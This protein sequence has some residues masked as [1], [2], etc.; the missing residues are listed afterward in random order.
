MLRAIKMR[1]G[2][3]TTLSPAGAPRRPLHAALAHLHVADDIICE[4]RSRADNKEGAEA[5]EQPQH[6]A[7]EYGYQG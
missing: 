7:Q 2:A 1:N 3:D 5:D 6:R 4:G